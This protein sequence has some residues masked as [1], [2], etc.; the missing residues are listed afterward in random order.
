MF[1]HKGRLGSVWSET[2]EQLWTSVSI[3]DC[4][5]SFTVLFER[6]WS[7][8]YRTAFLYTKDK[9]TSEGI[10][11]DIFINL[12]D[13]RSKLQIRSFSAYLRTAARYHVYKEMKAAQRSP[14]ALV[15]EWDLSLEPATAETADGN[16]GY[17]D[18]LLLVHRAM[19]FLPA[20][21]QEIFR[22]SRFE[23]LTNDEIA[24]KLGIS[25]RSVENQITAALHHLREQVKPNI[26]VLILFAL[27]L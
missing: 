12:W 7:L 5:K 1:L 6:Y 8:I 22:M 9:Q 13:K 21:C 10:T 19:T 16:I 15:G 11:H 18:A 17:Q 24:Q 3:G 14:I 25:K 2:D 20:R 26:T 4:T 27:W 23:Q